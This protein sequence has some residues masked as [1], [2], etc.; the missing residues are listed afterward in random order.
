[1]GLEC[2]KILPSRSPS[3]SFTNNPV[4]PVNPVKKKVDD[5]SFGDIVDY[6]T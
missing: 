2:Q 5:P 4:H 3:T 1:M 6:V